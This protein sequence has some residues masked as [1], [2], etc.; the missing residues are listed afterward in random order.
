MLLGSNSR[1]AVISRGRSRTQIEIW[2]TCHGALVST[3]QVGLVPVE[4]FNRPEAMLAIPAFY[5]GA[6]TSTLT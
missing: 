2:S 6:S 1:Y 5:L 4:L 3:L